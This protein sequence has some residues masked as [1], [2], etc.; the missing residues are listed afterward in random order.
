MKGPILA[1][2]AL[3]VAIAGGA[4]SDEKG[5]S[6]PSAAGTTAASAKGPDEPGDE[7]AD[8]EPED[9]AALQARADGAA[10]QVV[11][12]SRA[13]EPATV[14][15]A[16][17]ED[18]AWKFEDGQV[19]HGLVGDGFDSAPRT[20]GV[21]VHAFARAGTYAYHC[22]VHPDEMRGTVEVS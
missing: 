12:R 18:V 14:S 20:Q 21:V 11:V 16:A 3:A 17:G 15:I 9:V 1:A 10:A 7:S 8:V 22:P 4:C 13:F 2:T 6:P 19:P 5:S